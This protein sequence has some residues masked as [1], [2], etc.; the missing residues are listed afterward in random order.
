MTP[1][2]EDLDETP[3]G[4]PHDSE[5][6]GDTWDGALPRG[7]T[8]IGRL[9]KKQERREDRSD[10][11]VDGAWREAI[12]AAK[13]SA[14]NA[15]RIVRIQ[16]AAIAVLVFAVLALAGHAVDFSISGLIDATVTGDERDEDEDDAEN[17]KHRPVL[18]PVEDT[19]D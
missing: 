11:R 3:E 17:P 8:W 10:D 16:W 9:V 2:D 12:Q 18:E 4:V 7:M 1:G 13:E 15:W 14:T 5:S 6:G 19:A